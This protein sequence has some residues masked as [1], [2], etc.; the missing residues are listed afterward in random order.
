[1]DKQRRDFR[2]ACIVPRNALR[3]CEI[4][5]TSFRLNTLI[6]VL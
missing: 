4:A 1:L 6:C 3:D 2:I 5:A